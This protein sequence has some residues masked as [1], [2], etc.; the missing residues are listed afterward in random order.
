MTASP[1]DPRPDD[2]RPPSWA[3]APGYTSYSDDLP[4]H[5]PMPGAP[6]YPAAPEPGAPPVGQPRPR[7]RFRAA[8]GAAVT[9]AS[10]NL[11][12]VLAVSGAPGSAE[13]LGRF[14]GALGV[15]TLLAAAAVWAVARRRGWPF[16]LLVVVAAPVFWFLR[17]VLPM[18]AA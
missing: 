8:L 6:P 4:P 3:G 7:T 16:W 13:S 2:E 11:A 12:L 10:V 17:V 1:P 9:W 5:A 14:V 18:P 15:P